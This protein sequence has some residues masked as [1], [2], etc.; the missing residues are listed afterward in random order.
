MAR[1]PFS[2]SGKAMALGS[3]E[4]QVRVIYEKES[5]KVLGMHIM[6]PHATDLIAEGV[7]AIRL[8]AT[9]K[10]IAETI[11]AHPTLPEAIM[12]A[13]KAAAFGEAIHFRKI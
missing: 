9:A 7:M 12:E 6:G 1:F 8:G 2:A 13:A 11:H 3:M 10:D 4:G 5:G